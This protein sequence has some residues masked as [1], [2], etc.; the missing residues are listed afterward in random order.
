MLM[1][2]NIER[3]RDSHMSADMYLKSSQQDAFDLWHIQN[4]YLNL[5]DRDARLTDFM[6]IERRQ[7]KNCIPKKNQEYVLNLAFNVLG[8]YTYTHNYLEKVIKESNARM[9]VGYRCENASFG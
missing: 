8:S 5:P 6:Q 7:A 1:G 9:P 3:Y 2:R 4:A